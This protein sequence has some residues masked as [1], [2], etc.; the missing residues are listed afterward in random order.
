MK[1]K[2]SANEEN[3][4]I[5]SQL[6]QLEKFA[7]NDIAIIETI[8]DLL[9]CIVLINDMIRMKNIYMSEAGCRF[10]NQ[11]REEIQELGAGYFSSDNFCKDEMQQISSDFIALAERDDDAEV[12]GFYQKVRRNNNS[13]WKQYSLSG[14]QLKGSKGC[15]LHIGFEIEKRKNSIHHLNNRLDIIP[16]APVTFQKFSSLS[17]REKQLLKLI[18]NGYSNK[19]ISE[20]LCIALYTVKTHRKTINRKLETKSITDLI[21]ISDLFNS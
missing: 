10:L 11:S 5:S 16:L 8:G 14:K 20:H 21:R 1:K 2:Y 19:D 4:M 12:K 7:L 3:T 6:F 17:K 9:P 13:E 18:A 15:F